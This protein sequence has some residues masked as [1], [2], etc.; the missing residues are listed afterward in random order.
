MPRIFEHLDDAR[1][2]FTWRELCYGLLP[3]ATVLRWR[4]RSQAGQPLLEKTGPKKKELNMRDL[5]AALDE[6]VLKTLQAPFTMRASQY[7]PVPARPAAQRI[8]L[9]ALAIE[10]EDAQVARD[11]FAVCRQTKPL[12]SPPLTRSTTAL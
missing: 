10:E 12:M 9:F 11:R 8:F 4:A 6:Q 1:R 5:H 2:E 7:A 3:C